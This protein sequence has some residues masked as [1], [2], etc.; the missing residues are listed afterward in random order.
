MLT[1][2]RIAVAIV[3][4]TAILH[5]S[6]S[7]QTQPVSHAADSPAPQPNKKQ[8]ATPVKLG[9]FNV[10]GSWRVRMEAPDWFDAPGF[11]DDYAYVQSIFRLSFGLQRKTWDFNFELSQPSVLGLPDDAVAPGAPGQLGLGANY[12]AANDNQR[13]AAWVYPSK[14]Y[15]RFK[16]FGGDAQNQLTI[17]RFE[18][19]EGMEPG[20]TDKTLTAL[21]AMRIAHRLIGP[22]TFAVHGRSQDG[23]TLSLMAPGN[24]NLT[25]AAARPTR[26]VFQM[27]GL[28]ELDISWEYGAYTKPFTFKNGAAEFRLFG[29]G[30]QD[31]RAVAKTDNRP[32]LVRSGIDRFENINIGSYGADFLHVLNTKS[33]GKWDLLLWGVAQTGEWG[34]QDHRA[35]AGAAELG[36][37][38][39]ITS[40][41]PWLRVGYFIGSG[42]GDPNDNEHNTFFQVL[43]TPRWYARY[44]FYNLQ[45]S[46]DAS[47]TLILRPGTKWNIRSEYH[48]LSLASRN[49]LWYQGGGAFQPHTFG[50]IGRPSNGNKGFANVWDISAD[51]Q[52]NSKLVI[53]FYFANVWGH[54]V[55]RSIYPTGDTSRFGFTEVT[56]KF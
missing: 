16:N 18:F 40:L 15:L 34:V 32:A 36:W 49:D 30:Y 54:S 43:P 14:L 44:P 20:T 10:S 19:V 52:L 12:F 33:A 41:K 46:Q 1:V 31:Y 13:Y 56:Y 35:G 26:G 5:P 25:F 22:F 17:G 51:Y 48:N 4:A 21:K 27:D 8:T 53:G 42:D 55:I 37:Q 2:S 23:A 11:N 28:G 6:T 9:P 3:L 39:P 47:A 24:S 45:N 29:L 7:A 38:P 50:Y